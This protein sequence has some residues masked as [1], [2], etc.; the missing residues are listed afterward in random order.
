M[1]KPLSFQN[2][3]NSRSPAA[4]R[5]L[6]V[7]TDIGIFNPPPPDPAAFR[8]LCVETRNKS[9]L[10]MRGTQPPSGGCVLKLLPNPA[11]EYEGNQPPSG[12]CVLKLG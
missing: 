7:E 12:G 3:S 4:F 9:R 5:R 2:L 10:L 6:C 11:A 1:L 8:R